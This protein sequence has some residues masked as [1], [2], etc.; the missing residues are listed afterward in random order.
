MKR[1]L[2][3]LHNNH[4]ENNIDL[5]SDLPDCV[6]L[7]ILSFLTTKDALQTCILSKRW[8]HLWKHLPTLT[9]HSSHF[10]YVKVFNKF[11]SRILSLRDNSTALHALD[12]HHYGIVEIRLLKRI[13]KY[14]VSHN[15]QRLRVTL[16]FKSNIKPFLPSFFS[17]QT[18]TS[19]N[20]SLDP[21]PNHMR[22][23]FPNYLYLP[24]LTTLSLRSFAFCV[25]DDGR[26][27]PFSALKRLDSL[28]IK[29]CEVLDAQNLCISSMAL[30]NLTIVMYG[31]DPDTF[32][33]IELFAPSLFKF[34]FRGIPFQRLC[35]RNNGLS[36]IKH[37][38]IDVV[39]VLKSMVT[40]NKECLLN[41]VKTSCVLH[42]W[43]IEL[44]NVESLTVS[45]TTLEV[46]N[47]S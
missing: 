15:V 14:A 3:L 33:G 17:C 2:P 32:F 6:L 18:L 21:L 16:M 31:Y 35:L 13:I 19:V 40:K 10:K 24:V 29:W 27:E 44:A 30:V 39:S 46:L 1:G 4:A 9:I 36:S 45:L 5:L 25:G 43:L 11:V 26:V 23:L 8:N 12:F 41:S 22:P 34:D 37:A 38:N 20:V 28:S 42:N 47:V 7:H